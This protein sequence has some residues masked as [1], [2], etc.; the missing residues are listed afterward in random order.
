MS[1]ANEHDDERNPWGRERMK[2]DRVLQHEQVC[3]VQ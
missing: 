1:A 2:G 3:L